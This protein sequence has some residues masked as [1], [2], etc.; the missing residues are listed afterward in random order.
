MNIHYVDFMSVRFVRLFDHTR[1][2]QSH[3]QIKFKIKIEQGY[4]NGKKTYTQTQISI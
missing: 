4:L 3:I 2:S 1:H